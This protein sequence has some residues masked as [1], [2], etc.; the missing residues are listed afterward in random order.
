MSAPQLGDRLGMTRQ[1]VAGLEARERDGSVTLGTLRRVA[2]AMQCDLVY[3]IVPRKP[4]PELLRTQ[5]RTRAAAEIQRVAHTMALENQGTTGDEVRRLV[6]ERAD[7]LL[8]ESRR[9]LWNRAEGG[10]NPGDFSGGA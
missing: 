4:L 6:E 7:Q 9:S 1:G 3:A 10:R 2:D 5:A 8:R